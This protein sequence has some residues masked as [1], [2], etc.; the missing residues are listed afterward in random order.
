VFL[1]Q[2]YGKRRWRISGQQDL[3]LVEGMPLK[4]LK[5]FQ[6]EE[7]F[8][9]EP[10]DLLYLPPHYAH[11]GIA[12]GECMTYS[13]GFRAPSYQELGEAFLQFMMESVD[14]PGRYADPDLKVASHPAEISSAM[15]ERIAEQLAKIRFTKDDV[16]IFLG[17]YLSEPK[18]NVFFDRPRRRL[19]HTAFHEAARRRGIKLSCKTQMLYRGRHVFI[20]GE[21]FV[22]APHDKRH[23]ILLAD[24]RSLAGREMDGIS[25]DVREA[26]YAWYEDGWL[27]LA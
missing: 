27:E 19:S 20:N 1:L 24:A 4:I 18:M 9:L 14:L 22:A 23:L 25:N 13:V 11:D 21:A 26:L 6:P 10:G 16:T 15:L 7:E 8:V 17:E 2:A 3:T 12:V 5:N